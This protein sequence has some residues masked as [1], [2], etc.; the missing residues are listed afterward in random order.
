MSRPAVP[1]LSRAS[2]VYRLAVEQYVR[3]SP[4]PF[5]DR[6]AAC[7]AQRCPVQLHAAGVI[8]AAG[9]DPRSFDPPPRRPVATHWTTHPTTR[10]PAYG[11]SGD[12]YP[13]H[14]RER[15]A[16]D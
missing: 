7:R 13:T 8:A 4:V 14:R 5:A 1:V 3:H 6:C 16:Q 12:R 10:L 9:V 11:G 15:A 2:A